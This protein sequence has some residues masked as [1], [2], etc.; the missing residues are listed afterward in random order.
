MAILPLLQVC[1]IRVQRLWLHVPA[2][3]L[4]PFSSLLL[5]S[6][7]TITPFSLLVGLIFPFAYQ[8]FKQWAEDPAA[9]I[10]RLYVLEASGSVLGG[11]LFT[12]YVAGRID[13]FTTLTITG[14]AGCALVIAY[15]GEPKTEGGR[16]DDPVAEKFLVGAGYLAFL[17]GACLLG[18][19]SIQKHYDTVLARWASFNSSLEYVTSVES[20]YENLVV[21]RKGGQYSVFGNGQYMFSF[22]DEPTYA[23]QAGR[24]LTEHPS[25]R[26][27]LLIGGGVGGL[28][29]QMLLHPVAQLDYVE[30]DPM[31]ITLVRKYLPGEDLVALG[32]QRVRVSN[33]DGRYFVKHAPGKYDLIFINLPDP[34]TAMINRFYTRDFFEEA[35]AILEPGGV[36]ATRISSAVGYLGEEVGSYASSLDKTLRSVFKEV[37]ASPGDVN[38][39]FACDTPGVVT[40]DLDT[41]M[42]RFKERNVKAKYFSE[43]MFATLLQPE[44]VEILAKQLA[45]RRDIPLNTDFHPVTYFFNLMLW[46]QYAG[47]QLAGFYHRVQR[48]HLWWMGLLLAIFLGARLVYV[49]LTRG[50]AQYHMRFNV[51]FMIFGAGLAGLSWELMLIFMFQNIYGYVYER[52]GLIIAAFM[53]GLVIGGAWSNRRVSRGEGRGTRDE[54]QEK[55]TPITS[56]PR[57]SSPVPRPGVLA[58]ICLGIVIYSCALPL[59][60]WFLAR[61][62]VVVRWP[63]LSAWAI[64]ILTGIAGFLTGAPFPLASKIYLG[65]VG[66][67]R[68]KWNIW[69]RPVPGGADLERGKAGQAAGLVDSL[70]HL[71]AF[72]GALLTGVLLIPLLGIVQ[73]SFAVAM[74]NAACL[75]LFLASRAKLP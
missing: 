21:A 69:Q 70:D 17:F 62:H 57:P 44:Q 23:E 51:L 5:S 25:P 66:K 7:L 11:I 53:V 15:S 48:A 24:V 27:V 64:M 72:A 6:A 56:A 61:A 12:Y 41:L 42:K 29:R 18:G 35:K 46:D 52:V 22:P 30:M 45:A 8:L 59:I 47:R 60:L 31:L 10:G 74:V 2:G 16:E 32:D 19:V 34:S 36:L 14:L 73:T 40:F 1:L 26:K 71:G 63:D 75:A 28:L 54:G 20:R 58:R 38:Y 4:A 55:G 9:A 13:A 49:P 65:L 67:P 39:F 37:I 50:R 43:Y 68:S 33:V 3:E